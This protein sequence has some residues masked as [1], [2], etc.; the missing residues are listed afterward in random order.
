MSQ[1]W[2]FVIKCLACSAVLSASNTNIA[3]LHISWGWGEGRR[4][5]NSFPGSSEDKAEQ[6]LWSSALGALLQPTWTLFLSIGP[7]YT[8]GLMTWKLSAL[9]SS[10]WAVLGNSEPCVTESLQLAL[11]CCRESWGGLLNPSMKFIW[12]QSFWYFCF[13]NEMSSNRR[14]FHALPHLLF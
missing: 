7:V 10:R 4:E 1:G 8:V 12:L 5:Y 9:L 14:Q 6:C 3:R 2:N 11:L 13:M